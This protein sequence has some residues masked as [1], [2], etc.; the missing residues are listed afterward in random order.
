MELHQQRKNDSKI[1][2]GSISLSIKEYQTYA[3]AL[4]TEVLDS[5][6]RDNLNTLMKELASLAIKTRCQTN[7]FNDFSFWDEFLNEEEEITNSELNFIIQYLKQWIQ[8][9]GISSRDFSY[10]IYKDVPLTGY[11]VYYWITTDRK[12]YIITDLWIEWAIKLIEKGYSNTQIQLMSETKNTEDQIKLIGLTNEILDSLPI[13][14]GD[15]ET[16]IINYVRYIIL[17]NIEKK[18]SKLQV[19]KEINQIFIEF[20]NLKLCDFQTLYYAYKE[21]KQEGS[22]DYW[23]GMTLRNKD[24]YIEEY[25]K[26]WLKEPQ[27]LRP[28]EWKQQSSKRKPQLYF[29]I[30]IT[31]I[32]MH[33]ALAWWIY[34]VSSGSTFI[35]IAF[36]CTTIYHIIIAITTYVDNIERVNGTN[37]E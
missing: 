10:K 3:I 5:P 9:P 16:I 30:M 11:I 20:P 29:I 23:S 18:E 14:L 19:L 12:D 31:T 1:T 36:I 34:E 2:K 26:M 24:Q 32:V 22:Q 25:F 35:L 33:I 4:I 7:I 28:Q 13:L 17:T 15:V 27:C 8:T 21:L 6:N 37:K